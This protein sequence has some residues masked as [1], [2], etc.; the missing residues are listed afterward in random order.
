[1]SRIRPLCAL[2]PVHCALFAFVLLTIAGSAGATDWQG[3]VRM[4]K[5]KI[6][7]DDEYRASHPDWR[8]GAAKLLA[9]V[10]GYYEQAAGLKF[11]PAETAE[12]ESSDDSRD[13]RAIKTEMERKVNLEQVDLLVGFTGIGPGGLEKASGVIE[14]GACG[15]FGREMLI[16]AVKE[17]A[18]DL[19]VVLRHELGHV[20]GLAHVKDETSFMFTHGPHEGGPGLDADNLAVLR[21]TRDIDLDSGLSSLS[22]DKTQELIPL[23]QR[24]RSGYPEETNALYCLAMIERRYTEEALKAAKERAE[25]SPDDV[26]ARAM[27]ADLSRRIGDLSEWEKHA[28]A[29]VALAPN[30]ASAHNSLGWAL[31]DKGNYAAAETEFREAIRLQPDKAE[32]H[33]NLGNALNQLGQLDEALA[34]HREALRLRPRSARVLINTG[35]TL[36]Q[37]GR[38]DEAADAYRKAAQFEPANPEPHQRLGALM[39]EADKLDDAADAFRNAIKLDPTEARYHGGLAAVLLQQGKDEQAVR[40]LRE[41]IDLDPDMYQLRCALGCI[42]AEMGN[43]DE[44]IVEYRE[45]LKT[46]PNY[47]TARRG[48]AEALYQKGDYEGAEKEVEACRKL[49]IEP[50]AELVKKLAEKARER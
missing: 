4:L 28:R 8:A 7:A 1:M 15:L 5:V 12:W 37:L 48:L 34:A 50:D 23:Y 29:V 14:G 45:A 33:D 43:M 21:I 3:P 41:G 32:A 16:R 46:E 39:L 13:I 17:S 42:L 2:Y 27:L 38:I 19:G 47:T 49:G 44:A 25:K 11:E 35:L 24:L 18:D 10:S 26:E 40:E 30:D 9:S 20:F 6:A 22:H 31:Y 36:A